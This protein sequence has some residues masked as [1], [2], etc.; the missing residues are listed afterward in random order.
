M[1]TGDNEEATILVG[2][3]IG[4]SSDSIKAK[5]LPEETLEHLKT[6]MSGSFHNKSSMFR[7]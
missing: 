4:L 6:F 1:L 3:L 5:L 2:T 7:L